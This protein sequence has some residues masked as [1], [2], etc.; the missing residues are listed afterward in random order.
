MLDGGDRARRQPLYVFE[1]LRTISKGELL[2]VSSQIRLATGRQHA[3]IVPFLRLDILTL[4][5]IMQPGGHLFLSTIARTPLAYLL[6]ILA[7]EHVLRLVTPG[8]HTYSKYINP[9]EVLEFFEE[10]QSPSSPD[11]S[12]PGKPWISHLYNGLPS[13]TEAETRGMIYLPWKG[14]WVLVP[15]SGSGGTKWGEAC[16]YIFWVRR[17]ME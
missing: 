15:R 16:N 14:E 10:Y 2:H 9:D 17:P 7:A 5:S 1:Q 13:R 11:S 3:R 6:T 12:A 8:T 4:F